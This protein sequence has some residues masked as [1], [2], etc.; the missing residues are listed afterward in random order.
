MRV[1]L[2][3][4]EG[5]T[6][7]AYESRRGGPLLDSEES[8]APTLVKMARGGVYGD[9]VA[10]AFPSLLYPAHASLVTGRRAN[11]HGITGDW[12]IGE[13]GVRPARP[14]HVSRLAGDSLWL[15][16][17][18]LARP[19]AA[20]G[21]PTTLGAPV[22]YLVPDVV[23]MRGGESWLGVLEGSATPSLLSRLREQR[24]EGAGPGWPSLPERDSQLT[25]LA[26][27]LSGVDRPPDLWLLRLSQ[28]AAAMTEF[29]VDSAQAQQ[30]LSQTDAR[31]RRL[32]SCFQQ[33]GLLPTTAFVI[34][35]DRS[36]LPVHTRIRPNVVLAE[37]GLITPPAHGTR[38][39]VT[40]WTALAR[41]NGATAFVYAVDEP[42]AVLARKALDRA[43]KANGTF[44][45]VPAKELAAL[46]GDPQAWFGLEAEPGYYFSDGAAGELHEAAILRG[47]AG[48]LPSRPWKC[49]G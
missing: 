46:G 27:F 49:C 28:L 21:W 17:S 44:R 40:S 35:G 16:A 19:V 15:A 32:A 26:C 1:V 22:E 43:A 20:L 23:P 48:G 11:R 9:R 6:P 12:M 2:V 34:V 41:A 7:E 18:E 31:L 10:P 45:V 33:A 3:S 38:Q 37:A 47:V 29:G 30:A 8:L 36:V 39:A 24:P 14:W 4:I 42:S 5:L 13:A 25:E